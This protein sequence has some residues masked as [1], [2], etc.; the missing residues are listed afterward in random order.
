MNII[1]ALIEIVRTITFFFTCGVAMIFCY[2][3]LSYIFGLDS[4]GKS[5]KA[6]GISFLLIILLLTLDNTV[7]S[8]Y[9][10]HIINTKIALGATP[11]PIF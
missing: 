6:L 4:P 1:F 3:I 11:D 5:M 8:I 7:Y 10:V 9:H 2:N